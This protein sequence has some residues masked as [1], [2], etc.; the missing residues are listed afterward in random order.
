M[1]QQDT[2]QATSRLLFRTPFL[3]IALILV[4]AVVSLVHIKHPY[5]ALTIAQVLIWLI[6][7][8][9][10]FVAMG[11]AAKLLGSSWVYYG[12]LPVLFVPI[13]PLIAWLSLINKWKA[14]K[15]ASSSPS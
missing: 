8:V 4:G 14:L 7:F 12:L 13:G 2:L 5:I 10:P 6:A 1:N 3:V 9:I 11:R 15:Q